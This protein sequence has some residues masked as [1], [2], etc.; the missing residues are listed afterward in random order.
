[1]YTDMYRYHLQY[2]KGQIYLS[3]T[4]ELKSHPNVY[5]S[6]SARTL[7][8]QGVAAA[9]EV[10]RRHVNDLGGTIDAIVPSRVDLAADLVI[11][12]GLSFDFLH[13][14]LVTSA[15]MLKPFL[16][17]DKLQTLYIGEGDLQVRIY[18]KW[19]ETIA[20]G[21]A[22]FL[23]VWKDKVPDLG[24]NMQHVW[25]VE[26]QMRR[27]VLK[28]FGIYSV[29]DFLS[30]LP[31]LWNYLPEWASLR[32]LD[33]DN[34]TR[35]TIHPLWTLVQSAAGILGDPGLALR[36]IASDAS[37]PVSWYVAHIAGC[38]VGFASRL[39]AG[40]LAQALRL[41]HVHLYAHLPPRAFTARV[42]AELIRLGMTNAAQLP[43]PG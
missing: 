40:G 37:A 16:K 26:G 6:I 2:P 3:A 12:G 13:A 21:K 43:P 17:D 7:W 20:S 24:E 19:A 39:N 32:L 34:T 15:R 9:V 5:V 31:G 27:P 22:F 10:F 38:L 30:R 4:P 41:L 1:M 18:D 14:H 35:R 29:E 25:R 33:D 28:E 23:D 11:P 36:R 8:L 42:Q